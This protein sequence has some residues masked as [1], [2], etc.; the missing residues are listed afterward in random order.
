ML[1]LCLLLW[2]L[3]PGALQPT[4]ASPTGSVAADRASPDKPAPA[5]RDARPPLRVLFV[6]NSHTFSHGIPAQ[7]ARLAR[8][9]GERPLAF[10]VEAPGGHTLEG[11]VAG[12]RV[13]AHLLQGGFDHVV[14]QDQQQRPSFTFNP[15]QVEREFFGPA[16][17]LDVMAR[18]AGATTLL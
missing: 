18:A 7:V 15:E 10:L 14:L 11:H 4:G 12:G 2:R 5:E 8:E 3:A 13:A 6:G 9:A 16:R 17:T 1:G